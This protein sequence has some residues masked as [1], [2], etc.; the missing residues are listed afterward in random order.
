MSS[1]KQKPILP[2]GIGIE[3]LDQVVRYVLNLYYQLWTDFK[4]CSHVSVLEFEQ[5]N[6]TW[7]GWIVER[8]LFRSETEIMLKNGS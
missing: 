6:V 8:N 5:V 1:K 3:T 7:V 4:R 2:L